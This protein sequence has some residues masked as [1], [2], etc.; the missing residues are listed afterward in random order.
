M[1]P[2]IIIWEWR[3]SSI[4]PFASFK[5]SPANRVTDVVPSPTSLSWKFIYYLN[6]TCDLAMST[7]TF[8][9]GCT[10]SS[11]FKTVAPSF[12]I[13]VTFVVINLS[14]PL[15]PKVVLITSTID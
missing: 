15:G 14:I 9:A 1:Y 10:I 8:A 11:N 6:S 7:K 2:W 5:N 4:N 12:V 3:P 13:V